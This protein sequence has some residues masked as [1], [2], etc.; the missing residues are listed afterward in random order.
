MA[1]P[2]RTGDARVVAYVVKRSGVSFRISALRRH[3]ADRLPAAL[4]P[5]AFV[6]LD[7]LPLTSNSKIDRAA[8]PEPDMSRPDLDTPFIEPR[9]DLEHLI[10]HA[11]SQTLGLDRVGVH[12]DFFELGGDSLAALSALARLSE[13]RGAEVPVV[14][15]FEAPTVADL[16]GL[17]ERGSVDHGSSAVAPSPSHTLFFLHADYAGDGAYCLNIGRHLGADRL[18]VGLA[19]L[20]SSSRAPMT[21]E[22]IAALHVSEIRAVQPRGPYAIAGYC[23]GAVV[24]WEVARQLWL[25]G[26]E[27]ALV[28]L[29]EP[30]AV[31]VGRVA[32]FIHRAADLAGRFTGPKGHARALLFMTEL[33]RLRY[34]PWS[35]W[36]TAPRATRRPPG[37]VPLASV[38]EDRRIDVAEAYRRAADA[39]LP[40]WFRGSVLCLHTVDADSTVAAESWR[41]LA[42]RF[43]M[44]RLPGDHNSCIVTH[45]SRLA[46]ELARGLASVGL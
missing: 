5:S 16:A 15:L 6:V 38:T 12:D 31:D 39:Y 46:D 3:V 41:P 23:S 19:P 24:A 17:L 18:L 8:L 2:T 45:G 25:E 37:V 35:D 11:W 13:L 30:P 43:S 22:R 42:D 26:D 34:R 28:T 27:I 33:A 36:R 14:S 9:S 44:K 1:R 20:E 4:V 32:R 40:K 7:R 10:A 29:V 21:I